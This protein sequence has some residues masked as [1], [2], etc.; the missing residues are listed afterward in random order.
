MKTKC[1]LILALLPGLVF[2]QASKCDQNKVE[3][4]MK[5]LDAKMKASDKEGDAMLENATSKMTAVKGWKKSDSNAYLLS[6]ISLPEVKAIQ[7]ERDEIAKKYLEALMKAGEADVC[8][9]LE[10]SLPN[11]RKT[12]ELSQKQWAVI[13]AKVDK[14]LA[15]LGPPG[16]AK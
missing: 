9:A 7:V 2:G 13:R 8:S 4:E 14:D 5:A 15:A 6:L 1:L 12:L 10:R 3:S 11:L 16:A